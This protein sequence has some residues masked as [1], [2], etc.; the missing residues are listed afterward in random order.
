[1]FLILC[2]RVDLDRD[3]GLVLL[4]V[5][6]F[7]YVFRALDVKSRCCACWWLRWFCLMI[8]RL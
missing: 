1:M 2:L 3:L 6:V 8:T 4:L 7:A 5:L